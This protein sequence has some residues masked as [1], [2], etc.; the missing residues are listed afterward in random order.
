VYDEFKGDVYIL[1]CSFLLL[2][3]GMRQVMGIGHWVMRPDWNS[4]CIQSLLSSF[5]LAFLLLL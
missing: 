5:G 3:L 4:H 2:F 1:S